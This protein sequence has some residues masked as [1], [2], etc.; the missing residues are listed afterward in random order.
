MSGKN[1]SKVKKIV[2]T[3]ISVFLFLALIFVPAG[4]LNW[5]EAWLFFI[6]YI[7]IVV[8]LLI[9]LKKNNPDLLKERMSVKK[10]VK[11]WDKIIIVTYTIFLMILLVITG[12]DAV[13]FR[14]SNVPFVLKA[15]GFI[16]FIPAIVFSLWAMVK[17]TYASSMVRIQEN[18]GHK[19]CTTGPYRYVR[20][21]MYVGVIILVLCFP[22]ALGSFYAF[23][24]SSIIAILFVLRTLLE[25][26]TLKKELP[27]YK[28]YAKKV[29]YKL[30]PGIW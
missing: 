12:L 28:E 7:L 30:I 25:D 24:P 2:K 5:P 1:S 8:G 21:P 23:I 11:S 16:G 13:R 9:W 18:R 17:N 14:W 22:L 29:R 19:T 27:G 4:T 26:K 15:L 20:H 10:D 3:V 6:L